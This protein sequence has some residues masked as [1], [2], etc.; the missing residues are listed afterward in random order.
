MLSLFLYV[1]RGHA[2][3]SQIKANVLATE[4]HSRPYF[5]FWKFFLKYL[6][7][8]YSQ[9][10]MMKQTPHSCDTDEY[11]HFILCYGLFFWYMYLL[12]FIIVSL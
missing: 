8:Q 10:G 11:T 3:T 2:S 5:F 6:F 4:L 12:N 1:R 7:A 9:K